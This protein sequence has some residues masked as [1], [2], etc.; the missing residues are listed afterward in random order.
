MGLSLDLNKAES[1]L[2]LDLA[3]LGVNPA[4]QMEVCFDLDVSGSYDDEHRDGQTQRLLERLVPLSMVFDP[5]KQMDVFTFSD[6]LRHVHH[7][8]FITPATVDGF[9][10]NVIIDRVPGYNGRT[11]YSY[12]LERNLEHFG[13][14]E[15]T[16]PAQKSGGF[17]SRLTSSPKAAAPTT[18]A[19]KRRSLVLFN[20]DGS[21]DDE[22]RTRQVL[23]DSQQ[24]QDGVYFLFI[25]YAN[26][27]ARFPFLQKIGDEFD[28]TG[29]ITINNLNQWLNQSD[30]EI[31]NQLLGD[32]LVRWLKAA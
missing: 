11:D 17:F 3:K 22:P 13:W 6:G 31:N 28:N 23:R 32:E 25:A 12:V 10:K 16:A 15:A 14:K 19:A 2:K 20:T 7:A 5:D 4:V 24:R 9:I 18:P 27:G 1:K 8:G 30:E 26:Q 21:N 29:L